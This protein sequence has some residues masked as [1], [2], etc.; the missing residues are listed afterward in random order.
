MTP[1]DARLEYA[2]Q[3]GMPIK[4]YSQPTKEGVLIDLDSDVLSRILKHIGSLEGRMNLCI[5]L[6]FLGDT[7]I[8]IDMLDQ[9]KNRLTKIGN[10][11]DKILSEDPSQNPELYT[12]VN[13]ARKYLENFEV[14]FP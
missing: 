4:G 2:L 1:K 7:Q 13:V 5:G 14:S 3:M 10:Y 12:I 11:F 6:S 8:A 9:M